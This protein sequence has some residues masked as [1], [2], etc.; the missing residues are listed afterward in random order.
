MKKYFFVLICIP[1]LIATTTLKQST[2]P[3]PAIHKL[4]EITYLWE[5]LKQGYEPVKERDDTWLD[6]G[7]RSKYAMA[8]NY[9][10]IEMIE[11]A[12]GAPVFIR[13][14]H[15]KGM[16]FNNQTA[17][18][19]YNPEFISKLKTSIEGALKNPI[20]KK[21]IRQ[22]YNENFKSMALT[23][24]NAYLYLED[25]PEY[26]KELEVM[27]LSQLAQPEGT[28][29]GSFQEKFR[30]YADKNPKSDWYEAVTAPAFWLRRSI[31]GTSKELF[32][33][34]EIVTKELEND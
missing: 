17:F 6:V 10:S 25:N 12:F 16:D 9:A 29:E 8:K 1:F 30:A 28:L 14:P 3:D 19:Y 22:T 21:I 34:L 32:D 5:L 18:G 2:N 31:D 23:Y 4:M 24:K 13:G 33:L 7:F 27:Y 20:F 15:N 11:A 26:L